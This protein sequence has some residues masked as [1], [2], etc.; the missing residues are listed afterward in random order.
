MESASNPSRFIFFGPFKNYL[1]IFE[2]E[3]QW[4]L[5]APT[6]WNAYYWYIEES[7]IYICAMIA[8][9]T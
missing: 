2:V 1:Q 4:S 3:T 8:F 6:S 9:K 5:Q 7:K